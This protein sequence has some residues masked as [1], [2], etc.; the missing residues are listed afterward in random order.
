MN[1]LGNSKKIAI[2]TGFGESEISKINAFDNSLISAGI[3]DLNLIKVSSILSKDTKILKKFKIEKGS[4]CPCVLS[5]A[6]GETNEEICSGIGIGFNNEKY[7]FVMETNGTNEIKTKMKLEQSLLE[8]AQNRNQKIIT[9]KI[10]T[11]SGKITKKYG[12]TVT[13]VIYLF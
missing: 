12:C 1:C 6:Y 13:A 3:H 11:K 5:I 7:G 10:I 4:F 8:M 9:K 2:V